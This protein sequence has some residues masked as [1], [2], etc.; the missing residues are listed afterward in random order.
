MSRSPIDRGEPPACS[1]GCGETVSTGRKYIRGHN[2]R[3]G[4][5]SW[6]KGEEA[7]YTAIHTYLRK[8]FPK[9]HICDECGDEGSTDYALLH[10]H[11]YTRKREDYREL[12]RKCHINYDEIGG[13]RWRNAVTAKMTADKNPPLCRCGCGKKTEWSPKKARWLIFVKGHYNGSARRLVQI[14]EVVVE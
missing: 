13:S 10:G 7:G 9:T 6:Y 2:I 5:A 4:N 14:K 3:N 11:P 8:Y 12:C 1:C